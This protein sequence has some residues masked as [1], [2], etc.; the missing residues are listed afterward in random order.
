MWY[1]MQKDTVLLFFDPCHMQHNMVP[2]RMWQP[3]GKNGT[4]TI[5][6]NS[7][8]KR[9]N[10][11]G[12]L[13]FNQMDT[14]TTLT[15][16][17]CNSVKV[18]EFFEKIKETYSNKNIVIVL[19]NAS[20]NR[21]IYTRKYAEYYGIELFFLPPYSPNL[22]LIERLWKFAKKE[23]V[24]NKFCEKFVNFKKLVTSF[25]DN[26]KKY[27]SELETLITLKFQILKEV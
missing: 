4:I 11:L 3:K 18:V 27:K 6:S 8:R 9:I 26:I 12:A 1:L 14:I 13:N 10:I 17:S 20:Y 19:D 7:G 23:L 5:K 15:E 22:N 24:A 21:S 25:F 2:T 16:E